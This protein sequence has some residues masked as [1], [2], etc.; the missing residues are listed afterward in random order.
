M[1]EVSI[2]FDLIQFEWQNIRFESVLITEGFKMDKGR[3]RGVLVR[4]QMSDIL[5]SS[6]FMYELLQ[7]VGINTN[8]LMFVQM[9]LVRV[10]ACY[11]IP[12][13]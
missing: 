13:F 11:F 2:E 1:L 7:L 10:K 3:R 5:R 9:M 8:E 4:P 6:K 12:K